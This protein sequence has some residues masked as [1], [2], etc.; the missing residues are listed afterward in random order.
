MFSSEVDWWICWPCIRN[1]TLY[2]IFLSKP[3]IKNGIGAFI[4]IAILIKCSLKVSNNLQSSETMQSFSD[5]IILLRKFP[6]SE[7]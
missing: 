7:K 6:L 1:T 4:S 2:P 3:I 5:I